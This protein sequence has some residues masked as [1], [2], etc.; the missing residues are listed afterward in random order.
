[1]CQLLLLATLTTRAY[2]P[3]PTWMMRPCTSSASRT[4]SLNW[5]HSESLKKSNQGEGSPASTSTCNQTKHDR[6]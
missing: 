3:E 5:R 6:R 1:M 2:N 4:V